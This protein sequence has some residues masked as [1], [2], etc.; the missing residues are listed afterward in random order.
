MPICITN[1]TKCSGCHACSSI[2]P[3]QCISMK[4]D[5]EGFLYPLVNMNNCINCGLCEKIC[6]IVNY[7]S[8]KV[9][10]CGLAY[11]AVSKFDSIRENSSSGGIFSIFAER[12]IENNGVVFGAVFDSNFSVQTICV[13][14]KEDL[15]KLRGSKYVQSIIG[16]SYQEA[17]RYLE[18]GRTVLFSGTPCQIGGLYSYLKKGYDNLLTIDFICHGVP[19]P[20][21][22]RKYLD[23][24]KKKAQSDIANI[25]FRQKNS[26]W[27]NFSV[28][29]EF[30]NNYT[31]LV[32]HDNDPYMRAFIDNFSLRPSCYNCAFKTKD[33][34]ADITLA[35]FWGVE[36][37]YPE[38]D[39]DKGT[40]IIVI[41]SKK[42]K[43][44]FDNIKNSVI[45]I[46]TDINNCNYCYLNSVNEPKERK[47]FFKNIKKCDFHTTYKKLITRV[48]KKHDIYLYKTKIIKKTK[49][50][51]QRSIRILRRK[52]DS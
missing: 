43:N 20:L 34:I 33:R 15:S 19:S 3:N 52:N 2:C 32:Q 26:G 29:I 35:D 12:V 17:K 6:P 7:C 21:V 10:E 25:S 9:D 45:S 48:K 30:K 40:S 41:H 5:A 28:L 39:D 27:K 4:E 51:I 37:I 31:Y 16:Q 14:T 42:A 38:I 44:I 46:E 1:K 23:C 49:R 22:W 36:N 47:Y 13:D 8:P 24:Q 18:T 11:A 50:L